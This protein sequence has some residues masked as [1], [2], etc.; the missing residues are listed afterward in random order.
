MY[1]FFLDARRKTEF[2]EDHIITAKRAIKVS[3]LMSISL[4]FVQ[5]ISHPN[6]MNH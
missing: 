1:F 4:L 2:N 3:T 6:K 5:L